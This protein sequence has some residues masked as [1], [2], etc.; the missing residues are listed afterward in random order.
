MPDQSQKTDKSSEQ[1]TA[2]AI[3]VPDILEYLA[4]ALRT[5]RLPSTQT[6]EAPAS[7][8]YKL[9][10]HRRKID[11]LFKIEGFAT[12]P[13]WD[14]MLD[15]YLAKARGKSVS[16]TSATIGAACPQTTALRWMQVLEGEG[17]IMRTADERDKRRLFVLMTDRGSHL[18]EQALGNFGQ[19]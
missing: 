15:L 1:G 18:T 14:I 7:V 12:S 2:L 11:G 8:A 3:D 10:T 19:I 9:Y 16:V 6:Q 17:L 13:G 4:F 5:R